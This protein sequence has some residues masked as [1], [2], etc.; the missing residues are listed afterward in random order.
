MAITKLH[1]MHKRRRSRNVGLG[2]V[3]AGFVVLVMV[4]TMVKLTT[5]GGLP[6]GGVGPAQQ[7]QQ[8]V[9]E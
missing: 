9:S 1:E 2:A 3:L 7:G 8:E 6:V 4:L 5:T